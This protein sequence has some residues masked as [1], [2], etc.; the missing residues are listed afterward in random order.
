[1]VA[2]AL[3][4]FSLSHHKHQHIYGL[5]LTLIPISVYMCL[6]IKLR[7]KQELAKFDVTLKLLRQAVFPQVR[8]SLHHDEKNAIYEKL[9]QL[10]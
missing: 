5:S 10:S 8:D 6:V 4:V 3:D 7:K 2:Q 1:M 9:P